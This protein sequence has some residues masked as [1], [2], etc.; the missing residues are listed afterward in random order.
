MQVVGTT[1]SDAHLNMTI[2]FQNPTPYTLN[3]GYLHVHLFHDNILIGEGSISN[4]T[5]NPNSRT[6]VLA[7]IKLQPFI[8]A[9]SKDAVT[10]LVTKYICGKKAELEICLH[11]GS[12]PSMPHLSHILGG[13][14]RIKVVIPKLSPDLATDTILEANERSSRRDQDF[15]RENENVGSPNRGLES[16]LI[17]GVEMFLSSSTVQ[18]TLFNPL[19]VALHISRVSASASH[20]SD[21][22]GDVDLPEGWSWELEPGLQKT[23]LLLVRWSALSFAV[24][25]RKG[26]S[27]LSEGWEKRGEVSVDVCGRVDVRLGE[28]EMGQI[29][30]NVPGIATTVRF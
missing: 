8:T 27:M 9:D 29:E 26:M 3:I 16:P 10:S 22:L 7:D 5:S 23:P 19:N 30:V 17:Y 15:L 21:H 25:P 4:A 11:D 20:N 14:F 1:K 18:L 2:F 24:N 6:G 12:I 28:L 13:T